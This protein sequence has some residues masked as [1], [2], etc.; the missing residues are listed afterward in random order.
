MASPATTTSK[1]EIMSRFE[2]YFPVSDM[3]SEEN[4]RPTIILLLAPIVLITWKYYGT[5]TFYLAQLSDKFVLFNSAAM[6]AEWYTY[7]SA[8]TLLGLL[9][10]AV[11]KFIFKESLEA[12]GLFPGKWKL[13]LIPTLVIGA[14]FVVLSFWSSKNPQFIAEYPLYKGAGD[15]ILLF[16]TH[17]IV[18][19]FFYIGWEIFFRGF[20][21]V[22]LSQKFGAWGGILVQSALSCVV[23]IGKPDSEIYTSIL[24]ALIWG[25][26]AYRFKSIWPAIA[27]HWVLGISMDFFICFT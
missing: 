5:K 7:F 27:T 1:E 10:I 4:K 21:Q 18:Y 17:A 25:I 24:G 26:L 6:T 23:H 19:L 9:S 15:S 11:I 13:W 12:Y 8:F 22:G 2:N 16:A 20:M 14:V 3:F